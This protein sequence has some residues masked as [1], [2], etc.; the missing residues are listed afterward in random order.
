MCSRATA[1]CLKHDP[2]GP[3]TIDVCV[4]L[5]IHESNMCRLPPRQPTEIRRN[6]QRG[7]CSSCASSASHNAPPL[8]RPDGEK[9][10]AHFRVT[11]T[12]LKAIPFM[13]IN[14]LPSIGFFHTGEQVC[15][16]LCNIIYRSKTIDLLQ[17]ASLRVVL[18][19]RMRRLIVGA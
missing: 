17:D 10:T 14:T 11:R 16:L 2:S 9:K 7:L 13:C 5:Q 6:A 18:R 19:Q 3:T 8:I 1:K 4:G 12:H 15:N